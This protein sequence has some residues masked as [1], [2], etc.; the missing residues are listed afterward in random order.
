MA[1]RKRATT[2]TSKK[3]TAG[4]SAPESTPETTPES[5][6]VDGAALSASGETSTGGSAVTSTLSESLSSFDEQEGAVSST[7]FSTVS[8]VSEAAPKPASK[9]R[10]K[11]PSKKREAA[12]EAQVA[13]YLAEDAPVAALIWGTVRIE[14]AK[15]NDAGERLKGQR[16]PEIP[17]SAFERLAEPYKLVK[18]LESG[19]ESGR[20]TG[21]ESGRER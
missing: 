8:K 3:K 1:T 18:C 15:R 11:K 19:R 13:V 17:E 5:T 14:R 6:S 7:D 4:E 9:R 12:G 10:S 16:Y 2:K 21:R 20:E